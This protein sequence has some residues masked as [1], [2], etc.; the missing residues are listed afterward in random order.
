MAKT[1]VG[2]YDDRAAASRAIKDLETRGFDKEH[3]SF[4]SHEEG[5]RSSY[6]RDAN[7]FRDPRAL[8]DHGVP[9]EEADF[10]AEGLRRGGTLI[11]ARVHDSNAEEAADIMARHNP[12]RYEDRSK[13]YRESG[14]SSYDQN[15]AP[16]SSEEQRSERERHGDQSNQRFQEIEEHLK[17]GK[18]EAVRGG[19]R[20]HQRV[21]SEREEET[22]R[23][24]EEHVKVD[25]RDVDRTIS[26]DEAD[27]AF[28]D[29]T[30]EMVERS[31]EAVVSKEA[32]VTGEV[33]VGKE[34]EYRDETVGAEVRR[35]RVDVEQIP[36]E[37]YHQHESRFREH[38]EKQYASHN[39]DYEDYQHAYQ[40]GMAA[41]S[42]YNGR[43]FR[44]V[45]AH[46]QN[47]YTKNYSDGTEWSD[48]KG[49]VRSGYESANH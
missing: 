24:R 8:T 44:E 6:E 9:K 10:Y 30:T 38:Y 27:R 13:A 45:E 22:L 12:A 19:V 41:N 40:Y 35:V 1:I 48:V 34:T 42:A 14:H 25:R 49:A 31:E 43:D 2:L 39:G 3:L 29:D 23:L 37:K 21:E 46:L 26:E 16:F 7:E 33:A 15:A 11:V 5:S 4:M 47:D 32:R 20:V 36:E 17:V 18:R 28:K